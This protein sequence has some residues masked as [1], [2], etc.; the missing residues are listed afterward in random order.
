MFTYDACYV[1]SMS[2]HNSKASLPWGRRIA[3]SR[4]MM[5]RVTAVRRKIVSEAV[6][7]DCV[8]VAC[9]GVCAPHPQVLMEAWR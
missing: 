9:F 1:V 7:I 5:M 4:L 6:R 8:V 2:P 3:P